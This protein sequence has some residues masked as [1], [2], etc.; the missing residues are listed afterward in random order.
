MYFDAK[1]CGKRIQNLRE[2]LG[3][4]QE[5]FSDKLHISRSHLSKIEIGVNSPSIDLLV[6]I[7]ILGNVSI[8][9]LALGRD[10]QNS[11]IQNH[12]RVAIQELHEAELLL[13]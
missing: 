1:A 4:S 5:K 11:K 12:I 10:T 3:M 13:T 7:S 6:D 2:N 8:D 9:F